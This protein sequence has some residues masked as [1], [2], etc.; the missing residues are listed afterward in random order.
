[1][2]VK[3]G[4]TLLDFTFDTPFEKDKTLYGAAAGKP[5]FL[6]FLRYYGCTV[7]Q[8]DIRRLKADYDRFL[9]KGA[10][11]LVVLQSKPELIAE[12]QGPADLPFDIV[13]DPEQKLYRQLE[14][15]P[16]K[17]KMGMASLGLIKKM[18]EAKKEGLTH[19]EYEG[20]ELQ[21]P[22]LFLLNGEGRVEYAHYAKNL[23]DMPSHDEMLAMLH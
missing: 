17:S 19:G 8:L 20:D 11:V 4:D 16:A 18:N 13:C 2:R 12:K 1:M 9:A 14:I 15:A 23:T 6:M 21:L 5:V 22:A 10:K 7:C 3:V